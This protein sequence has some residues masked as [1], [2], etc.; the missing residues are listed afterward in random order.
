MS[1]DERPAQCESA[2]SRCETGSQ[3]RVETLPFTARRFQ[4]VLTPELTGRETTASC[5]KF[6]IR[7]KLLPLR[8]NELLDRPLILSFNSASAFLSSS[9]KTRVPCFASVSNGGV[10]RARDEYWNPYEPLFARSGP[11]TVRR[12]FEAN[13]LE[14]ANSG[15]PS[16]K[17]RIT[18]LSL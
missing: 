4:T 1:E 15:S 12:R 13:T 7:G 14:Y 8:S 6:S 9:H 5:D 10:D 16:Y 2:A 18:P 17:S 11:T 3:R